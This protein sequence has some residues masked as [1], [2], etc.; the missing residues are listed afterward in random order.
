MKLL[1]ALQTALRAA[2]VPGNVV[3]KILGH[4]ERTLDVYKINDDRLLLSLPDWNLWLVIVKSILSPISK[5]LKKEGYCHANAMVV[6]AIMVLD[7]RIASMVKRWVKDRCKID[8]DP[9]CRNPACC[10]LG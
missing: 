3:A 7:E 9:C 5:M 4:V 8:L 1:D 10:N 2:R 6:S